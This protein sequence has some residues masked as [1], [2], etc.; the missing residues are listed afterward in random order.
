M[1]FNSRTHGKPT[2]EWGTPHTYLFQF[3]HTRETFIH[4]GKTIH[5]LISI[6]EHTGNIV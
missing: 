1:S 4:H 2:G 3:P 5:N 6:P